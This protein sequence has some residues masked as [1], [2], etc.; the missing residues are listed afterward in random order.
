MNE[1]MAILGKMMDFAAVRHQVLA[2][3]LANVNTPT[4]KRCDV[5]FH[6]Q[7][8]SAIESGGVDRIQQTAAEIVEDDVTL[9]RPD[10]NNVSLEREMG[11]ISMN[12]MLFDFSSKV[13]N[14]K[15]SSLQKAMSG[16]S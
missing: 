7:L 1:T 4:Y 12:A 2:N 10:G 15:F 9:P 5:E 13:L 11:E 3:N 8:A 14:R 16:P 6:K